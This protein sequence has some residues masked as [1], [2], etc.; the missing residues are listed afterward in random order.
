MKLSSQQEPT[1]HVIKPAGSPTARSSGRCRRTRI[2]RSPNCWSA[3]SGAQEKIFR[4][5]RSSSLCTTV[6]HDC[7]NESWV[8]VVV[9]ALVRSH[10]PSRSDKY[11]WLSFSFTWMQQFSQWVSCYDGCRTKVQAAVP[12]L[13]SFRSTSAS[14]CLAMPPI[15]VKSR[16][17]PTHGADWHKKA[18]V[19][20][21]SYLCI[22]PPSL[23]WHNSF[24]LQ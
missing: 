3:S 15:V 19:I 9:S 7:Q 23:I 1:H 10:H 14:V 12:F 16:D 24:C 13:F 5:E 22:R 21:H 6:V 8:V 11:Q 17:V 20:H 2:W 4:G 18:A